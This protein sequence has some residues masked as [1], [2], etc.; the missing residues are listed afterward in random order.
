MRLT[1]PLLLLLLLSACGASDGQ[2]ASDR[3]SIVR[4]M[5]ADSRG[6]DPQLV[7]DLASTRIAADLF[8]GVTRFDATGEAEAGLAQSWQVSPDGTTWTFALRPGLV[9]SDGAAIDAAVF[10]KAFARIKDEKS[11]SPHGALFGVIAAVDAPDSQ[12][13]I[14]RLNNPFPQLPALLA[15]PAMAA[16]P[17]HRIEAA[18]EKW[19]AE[20]PLV[21]SGAYQLTEWRLSQKLVLDANP[22]WHGGR[23]KS[24]YIVWKPMDN[25]NSAMRLILA[26]GADTGSEYTPTRHHWLRAKHPDIVRNAPFLGTY[27]F[28]FNTRK[29]PF[30][31]VR[32]RRALAMAVDRQWIAEKMIDAGNRP[33]WGLLPPGLDGGQSFQPE[34]AQLSKKARIKMARKLLAEAGY[35]PN[36]P[37]RIEIRFNSS[38]EHRRAAVAM[39]TMWRE[40]GVEAK[41]LNSEASLHF[42]SLKRADF[43]LARSGW[44]ADLPAPENFLAVHRSDAGAQNYS[45]YANPAYDAALDRA[46]A[47]PD[48]KRRAGLM[49][50]AEAILIDDMPIL[51]LYFY[52]SRSL[53]RPE[54]SGWRDNPGNVHPSRTLWKAK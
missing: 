34:W 38:T 46:M 50:V 24:P 11:G 45:G 3:K 2:G 30:D 10:G 29:P 25:L 18:G 33:A 48:P 52:A 4:L 47:E 13:V 43:E 23:P 35:A 36:R 44:I 53:V 7:S 16:L 6:L 12:T 22:H 27:Y 54:I 5:E 41:L 9:F 21:T 51:P 15:H 20:R 39:A 31:D 28:A 26:G 17:F 32:V 14:V 37:L 49:R 42:D 19:A 1:F 40:L 8:E